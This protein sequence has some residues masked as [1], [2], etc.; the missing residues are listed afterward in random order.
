MSPPTHR[1]SLFNLPVELIPLILQ[2]LPRRELKSYALVHSS[3][4][5]PAQ[6]LLFTDLSISL[7]MIRPI[8]KAEVKFSDRLARVSELFSYTTH[9]YLA[10]LSLDDTGT[11]AL[12]FS[13]NGHDQVDLL[14]DRTRIH[15]AGHTLRELSAL[16]PNLSR[17]TLSYWPVSLFK[18][19]VLLH[20]FAGVT[21]VAFSGVRGQSPD[22]GNALCLLPRHVVELALDDRCCRYGLQG[23]A[24]VPSPPL[25]SRFQTLFLESIKLLDTLYLLDERGFTSCLRCL[26]LT[27]KPGYNTPA[28]QRGRLRMDHLHELRVEFCFRPVYDPLRTFWLGMS[29]T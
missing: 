5:Q 11:N 29:F 25:Q 9:L 22:F 27:I 15:F 28:P 2:H 14:F 19:D 10:S 18:I 24:S 4:T 17:L 21:A 16:L 23:W 3:W 7:G 12:G 26:D 6:R 1:L 20:V 13:H 8:P